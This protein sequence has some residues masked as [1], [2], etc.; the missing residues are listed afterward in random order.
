M[1]DS[2]IVSGDC[3]TVCL[4]KSITCT[5]DDMLQWELSL[6]VNHS[7][8]SFLSSPS[9]SFPCWAAESVEPRDRARFNLGKRPGQNIPQQ[10]VSMVLGHKANE[11]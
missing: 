8:N 5:T 9:L 11:V 6:S 10:Q 3:W 1:S 4:A 7:S 2:L